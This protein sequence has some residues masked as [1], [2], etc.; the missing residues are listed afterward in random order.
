[1]ISAAKTVLGHRAA[2]KREVPVGAAVHQHH[3]LARLA[4]ENHQGLTDNRPRNR[5]P[6]DLSRTARDIP[7]SPKHTAN[8]ASSR[9]FW[10]MVSAAMFGSA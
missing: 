8:L 5:P 3:R 7:M 10:R 4:A 1:M 9:A 2:G 6:G